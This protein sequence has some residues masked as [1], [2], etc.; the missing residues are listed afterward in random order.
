MSG[1]TDSQI[2]T[3]SQGCVAQDLF[4]LNCNYNLRMLDMDSRCPECGTAVGRSAVGHWLRYCDPQWLRNVWYGLN[5]LACVIIGIVAVILLSWLGV[6]RSSMFGRYETL[7]TIFV[8]ALFCT[9]LVVSVIGWWKSTTPE[10]GRMGKTGFFTARMMGRTLWI[11]VMA[12]MFTMGAAG[13]LIERAW[14]NVEYWFGFI[15]TGALLIDF[16]LILWYARSLAQ[17]IPAPA[18]SGTTLTLIVLLATIGTLFH[19]FAFN[20]FDVTNLLDQLMR[21][22]AMYART[23]RW[24]TLE[25]IVFEWAGVAVMLIAISIATLGFAYWIAMTKQARLATDTWASKPFH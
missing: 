19:V 10:P 7:E 23:M 17:R 2:A 9:P 11:A 16:I 25:E 6:L 13:P 14:I 21:N 15:F 8:A 24:K 3:D 1:H 20:W 5:C 18:L 12:L 22:N 4:C